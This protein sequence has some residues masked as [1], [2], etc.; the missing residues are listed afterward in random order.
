M[1]G[2]SWVNALNGAWFNT[3]IPSFADF[4]TLDAN[5]FACV[6]A[7]GG[8]NWG[9]SANIVIAGAGM[10][11]AGP[12]FIAGGA[13]LIT[14]AGNLIT[15][16]DNDYELLASGHTAATRTIRTSCL[17]GVSS[18]GFT[19]VNS[20]GQYSQ[21]QSL[22]VGA[23][24][25]IPLRVHNGSTITQA[26]L[27]FAVGRSHTAV[28]AVLP[29]IRICSRDG[30][31]NVTPLASAGDGNGYVYFPTPSSGS[32]WFASGAA[33]TLTVL[34]TATVIDRYNYSYFAEIVDESGKGSLPRNL[35]NDID[36][37]FT[38]IADTRPS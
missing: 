17:P 29:A 15:H 21:L 5:M 16:A 7:D 10:W 20:T 23:R 24:T 27:T 6:N 2:H 22:A 13:S 18:T 4:T 35:Y 11:F 8:G 33:Q 9:P 38:L 12:S 25:V 3:Y 34:L 30:S 14:S 19:L 31:G 32:A 1:G 28:P 36:L 37:T 26:V